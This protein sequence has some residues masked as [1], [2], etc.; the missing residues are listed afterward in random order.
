M[1]RGTTRPMAI[2]AVRLAIV[3]GIILR[4]QSTKRSLKQIDFIFFQIKELNEF[5]GKELRRIYF[6]FMKPI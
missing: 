2:E 6:S 4:S 5:L 1:Q 3:I